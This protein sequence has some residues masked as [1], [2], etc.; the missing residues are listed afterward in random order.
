M[1]LNTGILVTTLLGILACS[2]LA[3]SSSDTEKRAAA[4][5]ARRATAEMNLQ[6][7]QQGISERRE[8]IRGQYQNLQATRTQINRLRDKQFGD[9]WK[10]RIE[11]LE[12]KIRD[13]E[14]AIQTAQPALAELNR[15]EAKYKR[16]YSNA[17]NELSR[18]KS[19]KNIDGSGGSHLS[20]T[21][22]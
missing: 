1:K 14:A 19:S 20:G 9:Y 4:A 13:G 3:Q 6:N 11:A 15:A 16:D 7:V 17:C 18:V 8:Y 5:E 2:S 10:V 21:Y 22:P 12:A